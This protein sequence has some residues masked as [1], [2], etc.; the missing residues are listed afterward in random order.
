MHLPPRVR[1][2]SSNSPKT[3]NATQRLKRG[4]LVGA[5]VHFH[6]IIF[7]SIELRS[8]K[9]HGKESER[10]RVGDKRLFVQKLKRAYLPVAKGSPVS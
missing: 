4:D 5:C 10:E 8:K 9:K 7:V 3:K 6:V 2:Q 1:L